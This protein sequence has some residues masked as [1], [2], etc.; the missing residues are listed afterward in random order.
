[1]IQILVCFG[2]FSLSIDLYQKMKLK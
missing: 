1:M 2:T